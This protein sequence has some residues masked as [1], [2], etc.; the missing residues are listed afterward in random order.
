MK[1][2]VEILKNTRDYS[3]LLSDDAE[4]PAPSKSL[5]PRNVSGPKTDARPAQQPSR[6]SKQVA[7]D[8]GRPPPPSNV[9]RKPMPSSSSQNKSK[10]LPERMA[11]PPASSKS[12]M[13]PRRSLG[14]NSGSGP[15]RPVGSKVGVPSRSSVPT[16]GRGAP[17]V[18]R[19]S[20]SGGGAQRPAAPSSAISAQRRPMPSQH[21]QSGVQ[22]SGP[23][24]G[25]PSL[26]LRKPAPVQ[27]EYRESSKPKVMT[28]H[29]L[30]S[31]RDQVKRPP[32]KPAPR[33]NSA[34]ERP[35]AKPKRRP[36]DEG[37]DDENA[38]SMIREMFRYNPNK[39]RDDDDDS[40]MEAG[41]DDIMRE[42][43]R[44]SVSLTGYC[45]ALTLFIL[46]MTTVP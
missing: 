21:S 37:S 3:F 24:R 42:E 36:H 44:R 17:A 19:N 41:F 29:A 35:K 10:P 26:G 6:I 12:S 11:P 7:N 2:K 9:Q 14:S 43:K 30:P 1:K 32:P 8:R 13:D 20:M 38:I 39:F 5:P 15:G 25:Q 33:H 31:S 46:G 27:R 4:V 28:K 23:P 18:A 22:K 16:N 45:V 34:D 40:D